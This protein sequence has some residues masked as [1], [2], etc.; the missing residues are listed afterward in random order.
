MAKVYLKFNSAVIKEIPLNKD[1]VTIGRKPT[2]DIVID[3]PTIS[4]FHA[5]IKKEDDHF[6]IE[7][8]NSTNGTFINGRRIKSGQLKDNDQVGVA[9]HILDY[10][11]NDAA[12]IE[13]S[14]EAKA[15]ESAPGAPPA[16]SEPYDLEKQ[17]EI[18]RKSL[19]IG[20]DGNPL[21]HTA[22]ATNGENGT[23]PVVGIVRVIAGGVNGQSEV[24]LKDLVT[25]I[26]TTPQAAIKIKGFMVPDLAA[27]ISKRPD[28]FFL[29]AV[30]PGY[31]K[32]NGKP[33]QEQILLEN[34]ALIEVGGTNFVFYRSDAK[35]V[36]SSEKPNEK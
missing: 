30:K 18:L 16:T 24:T 15:T 34:G 28:G 6:V 8:L 33:I 36:L 14:A 19:G 21:P 35:K 4:G 12:V 32:V 9:G 5:K 27:A 11:T 17:K 25:Y 1:E 23:E 22:A 3:H 13:K 10:H 26:G 2:N 7:D 29:K 20:P 31:P